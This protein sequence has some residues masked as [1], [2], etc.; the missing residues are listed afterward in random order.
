MRER[1]CRFLRGTTSEQLLR[2][3]GFAR[4]STLIGDAA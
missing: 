4:D 2:A 3:S 1:R